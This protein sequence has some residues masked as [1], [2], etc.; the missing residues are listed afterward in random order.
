M[1]ADEVVEPP[2]EHL[3][4][5]RDVAAARDRHPE[6]QCLCGQAVDRGVLVPATRRMRREP[7][8]R[9]LDEGE[10]GWFTEVVGDDALHARGLERLE[11]VEEQA[12]RVGDVRGPA[13]HDEG[14][15]ASSTRTRPCRSDRTRPDR[16]A[17]SLGS[18]E[19]F[20]TA[21]DA[22]AQRRAP[23][24]REQSPHD[25]APWWLIA[26]LIIVASSSDRGDLRDLRGRL[27]EVG[28][29]GRCRL[30]RRRAVHLGPCRVPKPHEA[31]LDLRVGLLAVRG[32][33]LVDRLA[34]RGRRP[35]KLLGAGQEVA[36]G[37]SRA[38]DEASRAGRLLWRRGEVH[39]E[40]TPAGRAVEARRASCGSCRR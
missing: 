20:P 5:G 39:G 10:R 37:S 26:D 3:E 19:G 28:D 9:E 2:R 21:I 6:V 4:T 1:G 38:L 30:Q 34:A 22:V 32:R 17:S 27:E 13:V 16:S 40:E 35:A 11:E 25:E 36:P 15:A 29:R 7:T 33:E 14:P 12:R 31:P 23:L 24:G 8:L 18:V